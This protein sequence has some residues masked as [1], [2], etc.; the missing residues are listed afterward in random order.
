MAGIYTQKRI[1]KQDHMWNDT[2]W[3]CFYR[4]APG[5]SIQNPNIGTSIYSQTTTS[6]RSS[7]PSGL[8]EASPGQIIDQYTSKF[9]RPYD[10]GHEFS[11]VKGEYSFSHKPWSYQNPN[12]AFWRGPL[13]V[14]ISGDNIPSDTR[15]YPFPAIDLQYGTKAIKETAPTK[16]AAN[17]SQLLV[18]TIRDVPRLPG[19]AFAKGPQVVGGGS[20]KK[21]VRDLAASSG[22][23][24]L[25]MIFGWVPTVSDVLKICESVVKFDDRLQQLIK[26][27]GR[28]IRRRFDFAPVSSKRLI[29]V[30]KDVALAGMGPLYANESWR[31]NFFSRIDDALGVA[32]LTEQYTERYYFT[33]AYTYLLADASTPE[34]AIAR[35]A[36]IAR[37]LLGIKG[38]TPDLMWELAPWSW[39]VDWFANIGDILTNASRF[40]NDNLVLRW[41]YLMRRTDVTRTYTHSGVVF[42]GGARTG[43]IQ[44]TEHFVQK[45]RVRA[46]PYGFGL[47]T[48]AFSTQ[49][50]AILA[51]L[52]MTRGDRTLL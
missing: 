48:D 39:L 32:T 24:Y 12:G 50:W 46:T 37:M 4:L 26:D 31:S 2:T 27:S 49:Q 28:Q 40:Q 51:A 43:P 17:L 25:N 38:L 19:M 35:G 10:R 36:Q 41:G 42:R 18:E 5:F 13:L 30:N 23:E 7:D 52:G 44:N 21:N 14:S 47:N 20:I 22:D 33:G 34:G 3:E 15:N 11:T 45:L 29:T 16:E 6:F 1:L 9:Q 8:T